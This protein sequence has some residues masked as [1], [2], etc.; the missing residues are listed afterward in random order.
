MANQ[1]I[2]R[3]RHPTPTVVDL[4][5]NL[6]G[7][8][9]FSKLDLKAGYHQIPLASESRYITTF[10]THKGLRRYARLNFGTNSASEVFQNIISE[11]IRDI[12]GSMNISDD[13]IVYGKTQADHNEALKA[14][15]R[16]LAEKNLTLK[17]RQNVSLTSPLCLFLDL[18]SRR[19]AS[20]L[21]H[22]K[23]VQFTT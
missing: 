21:T 22:R 4:I 6:N 1:A 19:M 2:R 18:Y 13:I 15:F 14:V 11:L 12:P 8:T 3:E 17:M 7:A 20:H 5:H 23:S 16:K 10:S 9:V